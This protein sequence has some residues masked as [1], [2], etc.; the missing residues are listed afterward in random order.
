MPILYKVH[1][2]HAD[3]PEANGSETMGVSRLLKVFPWL[4]PWEAVIKTG[5]FSLSLVV[6]LTRYRIDPL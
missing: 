4:K 1:V 2:E 6:N 3:D 5:D